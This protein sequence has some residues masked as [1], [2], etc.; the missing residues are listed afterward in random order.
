MSNWA[1][2]RIEELERIRADMA[3]G[4]Q[5]AEAKGKP[6]NYMQDAHDLAKAEIE[7]IEKL[8]KK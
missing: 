2:Q 8:E 1:K 6:T 4:I 5:R 7:R 3:A